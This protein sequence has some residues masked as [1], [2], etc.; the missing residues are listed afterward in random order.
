[1]ASKLENIAEK[2]YGLEHRPLLEKRTLNTQLLNKLT[3][4]RRL[5]SRAYVRS[6]VLAKLK[7]TVTP[8]EQ[9]ALGSA[10]GSQR[11]A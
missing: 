9:A 6:T 3:P 10:L 4:E 8:G 7:S 5:N 1:M 11:L 2:S